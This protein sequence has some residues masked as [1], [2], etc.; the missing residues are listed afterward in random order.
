MQLS[1]SAIK[2]YNH[3]KHNQYTSHLYWE[4]CVDI[5]RD[6]WSMSQTEDEFVQEEIKRQWKNGDV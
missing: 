5:G 4:M 1:F 3:R 6:W 2:P